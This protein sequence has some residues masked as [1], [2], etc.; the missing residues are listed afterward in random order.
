MGWTE[1]EQQEH[2]LVMASICQ[3]FRENALP[4]V[5]KG[6]TALKLCYNLDRFSED[7]DFDSVKPLNLQT[8]INKVFA[9]LGKSRPHLRNPEITI[10]KDTATVRRYRIL[11]GGDKRLKLETSFRHQPSDDALTEVNGILTYKISYLIQQKLKAFTGRTAARDLHDVVYLYEH[12][13]EAF[14][15]DELA[16]IDEIYNNQSDIL[17]EYNSAYA[18]DTI[19]KTKDLLDDYTKF[20]SLYEKRLENK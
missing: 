13:F 10:T 6:G 12:Y 7:L 8:P 18:E 20:I 14:G 5:L 3:S 2:T 1:K 16:E 4:M 9:Q 11:Y 15:Q 17:D 19:L